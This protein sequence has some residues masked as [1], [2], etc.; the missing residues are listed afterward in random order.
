[1][2]FGAV[3]V[4]AGR[5]ER[6]GMARPKCMVRIDGVP[7]LLMS[8]WSFDRM[9]SVSETVL[10][11]PPDCEAEVQAA[12]EDLGLKRVI[13][14]VPGGAR[15][16]DSV[17]NGLKVL[18]QD[19][20]RVLIHDGARPLVSTGLIQRL[21]EALETED[22]VFAGIPVSDTLH[23]NR[24][25]HAEEGPDRQD[26]TAAQTPQG[27]ERKIL[28]EALAEAA[29]RGLTFTDDVALVR[30]VTG[31]KARIIPGET[32]NI[33]ITRPEDIRLHEFLLKARVRQMKGGTH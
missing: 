32:T 24:G 27:F 23:V 25:G 29:R 15:R 18:S 3:V 14:V 31:V 33:K 17:L 1:M 12:C 9:E 6:L 22:A 30:Q 8:A 4:G 16:Q 26:L 19:V 11:V 28:M 21:I 5:G 7:L 20:A 10:V 13:S 2:K